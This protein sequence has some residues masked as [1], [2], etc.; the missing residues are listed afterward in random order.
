MFVAII[1]R[2]SL[3]GVNGQHESVSLHR[4]FAISREYLGSGMSTA[5]ACLHYAEVSGVDALGPTAILRM[6]LLLVRSQYRLL[7]LLGLLLLR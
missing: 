1:A 2:V 5:G 7:L 4:D 3:A 6:Q